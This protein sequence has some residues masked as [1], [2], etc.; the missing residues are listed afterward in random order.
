MDFLN[1]ANI[2][3]MPWPALSPDLAPIEHVLDELGRRAYSRPNK[4]TTVD[5]LHR[6]L[7]EEWNNM[8]QTVIQ[9]I[10]LSMRRRC[11]ACINAR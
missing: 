5:D 9:N 7:T 3:V 8:P 1:Y 6:A 4:P 2:R 11:T 10:I